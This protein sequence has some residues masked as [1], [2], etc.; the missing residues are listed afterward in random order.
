MP[1]D[2]EHTGDFLHCAEEQREFDKT[3]GCSNLKEEQ[4][5]KKGAVPS[6]HVPNA[7]TVIILSAAYISEIN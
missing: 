3:I 2:Q 6:T 5:K 4:R 1:P 7:S